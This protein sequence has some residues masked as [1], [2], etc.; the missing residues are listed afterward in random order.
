M[1]YF[2]ERDGLLVLR[3]VID[4]GS[5]DVFYLLIEKAFGETD[6]SDSLLKLVEIV[7]RTSGSES[8]IVKRKTL[9]DVLPKTLRRPYAELGSLGR[10][11]PVSNRYY[12]VEIE[13]F[14]LA[15]DTTVTFDLNCSEIPN[16][17]RAINLSFL[18]NILYVFADRRF[19][20]VEEQAKLGLRKPNRFILEAHIYSDVARGIF[21][22]DDLAVR[23]LVN[24][25]LL[26]LAVSVDAA[27]A[28]EGPA[29]AD[30]FDA[31]GVDLADH[32]LF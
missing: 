23:H 28:E 32:D 6:R 8:L 1:Y 22:Q 16:S 12:D 30:L 11:H 4:A 29:A 24:E 7:H 26:D 9:N 31:F 27:V 3:V 18:E 5:V 13:V 14:D 17:C 2:E 21:V 20:F 25:P 15:L 19:R 10:L